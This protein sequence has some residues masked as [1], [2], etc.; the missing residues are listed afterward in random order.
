MRAEK[1]APLIESGASE[2]FQVT[3][4]GGERTV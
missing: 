2:N 3:L 4:P 1:N